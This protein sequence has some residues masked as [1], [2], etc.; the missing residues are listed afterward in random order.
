MYF[1]LRSCLGAL[2]D[3][4]TPII[5]A[6][7]YTSRTAGCISMKLDIC[8]FYD[9]IYTFKFFFRVGNVER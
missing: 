6:Q 2:T 3:C 9:V 7:S 1:I 5:F 8:E 4:I